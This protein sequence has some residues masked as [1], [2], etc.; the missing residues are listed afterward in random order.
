MAICLL[1]G[2]FRPLS[3]VVRLEA[4][5]RFCQ[6]GHELADGSGLTPLIG[7]V[8]QCLDVR[9]PFSFHRGLATE[10]GLLPS[11]TCLLFLFEANGLQPRAVLG[12]PKAP[13][14]LRRDHHR[15]DNF[16]QSI[17]YRRVRFIIPMR[18]DVSGCICVCKT[19]AQF[20]IVTGSARPLLPSVMFCRWPIEGE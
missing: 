16:C 9:A 7:A 6:I 8:E 19:N 2:P 1:Q 10:F 18:D 15:D 20:V 14:A 17:L 5:Q 3:E 12:R 13:Q 11:L 4:I